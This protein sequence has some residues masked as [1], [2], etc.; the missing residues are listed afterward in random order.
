[1]CESMADIQS[2]TAEIRRGKK[3]RR[4]KEQ[5]TGWK[6]I[7]SA[8]LH[9]ATINNGHNDNNKWSKSFNKKAASD[10]VMYCVEMRLVLTYFYLVQKYVCNSIRSGFHITFRKAVTSVTYCDEEVK[11]R[12]NKTGNVTGFNRA[13]V[14]ALWLLCFCAIQI[15]LLTKVDWLSRV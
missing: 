6:Y 13:H 4:K 9:R 1:M 3:K 5:T 8:L 11:Q 7:W 14:C 2:P 15:H 10:M 12:K